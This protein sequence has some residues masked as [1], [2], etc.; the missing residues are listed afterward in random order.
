M[1]SESISTP[2]Q[3]KIMSMMRPFIRLSPAGKGAQQLLPA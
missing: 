2:S 3:S 1:I